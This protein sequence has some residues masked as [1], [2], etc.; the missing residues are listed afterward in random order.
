MHFV[1]NVDGHDIASVLSRV[2]PAETLFIVASKTFTTQET[3]ANAATAKAWFLA[4]GGREA[5]IAAHFVA[6]T[7][8]VEAAAR[9]GITTTFGFRDW[10]GGRYS[11][12][13]AIGLPI[14]IAVGARAFA[15]CSP[16]RG[17]WTSTSRPRRS[18][19]TCRCCSASSTSGTATSTASRA[20]ASRRTTTA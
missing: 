17:R 13:S 7:T 12:W 14:A 11:L 8:N 9:F 16:A 4:G 1:S 19:R 15:S 18:R 10:V 20:A 5:D 2:A 3:M 6:A